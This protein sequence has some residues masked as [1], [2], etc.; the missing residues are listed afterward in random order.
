MIKYTYTSSLSRP[1]MRVGPGSSWSKIDRSFQFAAV[2]LSHRS[3]WWSLVSLISFLSQSAI[4]M[5]IQVR[6]MLSYSL[7][8]VM[9][10]S[11]SE[12]NYIPENK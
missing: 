1:M 11:N 4:Q 2:W 7:N 12:F 9:S 10:E 3:I 8:E 5:F 6:Y